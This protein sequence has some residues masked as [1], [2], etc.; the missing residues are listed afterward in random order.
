VLHVVDC[1]NP[2]GFNKQGAFAL[3]VEEGS[4]AQQAGALLPDSTVVASVH[5]VCAVLLEDPEFDTVDT[6]L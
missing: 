3:G 5:H 4:A 1:V 6:D 2:L